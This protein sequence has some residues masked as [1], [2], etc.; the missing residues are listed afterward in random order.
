MSEALV[1]LGEEIKAAL[2][3]AVAGSLREIR[4]AQGEALGT[5]GGSGVLGG[6]Y[7]I[8][9]LDGRPVMLFGKDHASSTAPRRA[10]P[11]AIDVDRFGIDGRRARPE[12]GR[13]R[14]LPPAPVFAR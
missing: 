10:R 4:F 11:T 14:I 1:Q 9:A 12:G 8:A 5:E 13:G 3:G 2:P 6:P 7:T